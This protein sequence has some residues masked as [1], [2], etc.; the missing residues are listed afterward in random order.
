MG[1]GEGAGVR[2]ADITD[3]TSATVL[4]VETKRTVPWTKPEDL[5]FKAPEDGKQAE[6]FDGLGL[7]CLMVDGTVLSLDVPIDWERLG[8]L[9]T[10]NGGEPF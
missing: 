7:N 3:G 10:R 9:V 2:L 6:P 1:A 5:L 4:L 8:R